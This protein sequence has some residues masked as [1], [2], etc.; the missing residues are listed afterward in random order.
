MRHFVP[1]LLALLVIA[2]LLRIDLFF[3]IVYFLAGVYILSRLWVHHCLQRVT[4]SRRF[5]ERA[6]PGDVVGITVHVR[7]AGRLPVPWLQ[8]GESVP[9][10][11]MARPVPSRVLTLGSHEEQTFSYQLACRKRGY[12][13]LGPFFLTIGDLLGADHQMLTRNVHDAL[14]IYPRVVP[15]DR[16]NLQ[17]L[18]VQS[19]LPTASP[20]VEDPTRLLGVRDYQRGDSPRRIHWPA[21]GRLSHLVVKQYE[22]AIARDTTIFLDLDAA[23]YDAWDSDAAMELAIV[24]AASLAN[25]IIVRNHLPVGLVTKASDALADRAV[26]RFSLPPRADRAQLLA[27]LEALARVN[28]IQESRFAAELRQAGVFLAWGASVIAITGVPRDDLLESL[29]YLRRGGFAVSLIL[30]QPPRLLNGLSGAIPTHIVQTER[31]LEAVP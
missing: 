22:P 13:T 7:N 9:V 12:F 30:V 6:F 26:R 14:L 11:L 19:A 23:G 27:I 3:T 25:H 4:L 10:Q 8:V 29:L 17:A 24:A 15:I 20:L 2:F 5:V 28:P 16:L 31:D 21:T 1:F 18:A